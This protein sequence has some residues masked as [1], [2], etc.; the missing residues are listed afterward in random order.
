MGS[1]M[2]SLANKDKYEL[3]KIAE[4][5][6]DHKVR[7]AAVNKLRGNSLTGSKLELERIAQKDP[8]PDV[9]IA[10]VNKLRGNSL[11]ES[12]LELEVKS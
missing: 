7:I 4:S 11:T 5:H 8:N 12:K 3:Q 1:Y 10:A 9:R 2:D 6:A